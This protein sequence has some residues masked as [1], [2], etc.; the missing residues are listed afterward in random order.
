MNWPNDADGDVLRR[1]Q[2]SGFDFSKPCLIDFDVD[3]KEWPPNE[4]ALRIL[5]REYPS[6]MVYESTEENKGYI[7]FQMF[8]LLSY[9][10]VIRT[11]EY[12]TKL[13]KPFGGVCESWGVLH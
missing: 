2:K 3:F 6:T 4:A 10:L 12:V 11:Q 8:E 13:M 5:E 7:E 9:E 1:M